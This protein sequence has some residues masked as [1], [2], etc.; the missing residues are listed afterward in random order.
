[1]QVLW[2]TQEFK[3]DKPPERDGWR[4]I[5]T[6]VSVKKAPSV[7]QEPPV[8]CDGEDVSMGNRECQGS[9]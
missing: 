9:G 5:K 1:M 2:D 3:P 4:S 7:K 8:A 6:F